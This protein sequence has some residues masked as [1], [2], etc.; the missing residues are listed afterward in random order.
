[1]SGRLVLVFDDGYQADYTEIRPVLREHDIP[2]CFAVVPD[3]LGNDGH[4]DAEQLRVLEDD[5]YEVAAHG[6]RHRHLQSHA[7][8]A[9]AGAGDTRISVDGHVFPDRDGGVCVGD[10]YELTDGEHREVH[11]V[12]ATSAG[13]DHSVV[14]FET[15]LES[16]FRPSETVVRVTEDVLADEVVGARDR[17]A[18]LGFDTE[19]F[20]FP[21]DAADQRA[22][23]LAA[24][25]YET[26]PNAA[27]R[28]LPNLPRT[29]AT[30]LRRYYLETT[31]LAR[32]EIGEYLDRVTEQDGLGILA[33]HSAWESVT[34]ERLSYVVEAARERGVEVTT[35]RDLHTK[36]WF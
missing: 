8:A 21:Y 16:D 12:A 10:E 7:L 35:F 24:D 6:N 11:A 5:G 36:G 3:W 4:L 2:A 18:E 1:M 14:G 25:T 17:L 33:G 19:A 28:S 13:E 20:V 34:A 9:P 27:V 29:P 26:L 22:W 31:H 15:P 30:N 32:V 23:R